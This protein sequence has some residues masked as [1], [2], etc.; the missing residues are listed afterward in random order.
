[1]DKE[2]IFDPQNLIEEYYDYCANPLPKEYEFSVIEREHEYWHVTITD[3]FGRQHD[4]G[5]KLSYNNSPS[6][7]AGILSL[8]KEIGRHQGTI[9]ETLYIQGEI[10]YRTEIRRIY[11]TNRLY[12]VRVDPNGPPLHQTSIV[13]NAGFYSHVQFH[14][15][16]GTSEGP[17]V[18][19]YIN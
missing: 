11:K 14:M 7:E 15:I 17:K 5:V 13:P 10:T 16:I 19:S 2:P 18:I 4:F 8:L 6:G 1:M 3:N 12:K 9:Y